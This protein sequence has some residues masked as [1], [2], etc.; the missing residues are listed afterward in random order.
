VTKYA[1]AIPTVAVLRRIAALGPIIEV[2]AG[3]GY[4]AMELVKLGAD[5]IAT[6]A[7][8]EG[9]VHSPEPHHPVATMDATSAVRTHGAGRALMLVWP[10]YDDP[11]SGQALEAY[12]AIGGR[13]VIYVGESRGG[14]TADDAFHERLAKSWTQEDIEIPQW[15]GIHDYLTIAKRVTP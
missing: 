10:S 13:T 2:G 15:Y 12:E 3:S 14:C 9:W 11:W 6:D 5:I 8:A 1:W 4:W 7:R